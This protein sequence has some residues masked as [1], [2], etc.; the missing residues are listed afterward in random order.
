MKTNMFC[1]PYFET[2][3]QS[4]DFS[5]HNTRK[6]IGGKLWFYGGKIMGSSQNEVHPIL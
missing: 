6:E 4:L 1:L 2:Y 5:D 3:S